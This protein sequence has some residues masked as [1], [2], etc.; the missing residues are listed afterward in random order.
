MLASSPRPVAPHT[1]PRGRAS[2]ALSLSL[3]PAAAARMLAGGA[4]AGPARGGGGLQC[5]AGG[6]RGGAH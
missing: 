4:C 2:R 6:R 3:P 5:G 1:T